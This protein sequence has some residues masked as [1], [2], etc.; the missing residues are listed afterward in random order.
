MSRHPA[1]TVAPRAY[2]AVVALLRPP[3]AGLTR[4]EW[5]GSEHLPREGGFIVA[6]NHLSEIDPFT[7]AHF[8]VDHGCPPLFL[9]KASLFELPVVGKALHGLGQVPVHRGTSQAGSALTEAEAAV[10]NGSCVVVMPEGTLTRDPALWPMRAKTGVG[11]LALATRAP[12][13]PIGQWGPQ[14]LLAPYARRPA[15]KR[16]TMQVKAGPPV[17]LSDLYDQPLGP[18]LLRQATDRVMGKVTALVAD[19]RG[20]PAPATPFEWG[21]GDR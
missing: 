7:L 11:R 8:L 6:A 15:F 9:A 18:A 13:I 17:D 1:R 20:V 14:E 2:R 16:V 5:S 12:V 3:I 19:L 10:R 4:Q 21:G